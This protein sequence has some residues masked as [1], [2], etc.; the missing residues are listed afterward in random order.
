M[1]NPRASR[2]GFIKG[3]AA[4]LAGAFLALRGAEPATAT[5]PQSARRI[6][7]PFRIEYFDRRV[8]ELDE[9]LTQ[10]FNA[11]DEHADDGGPPLKETAARAEWIALGKESAQLQAR[12][13]IASP[14]LIVELLTSLRLRKGEYESIILTIEETRD[15]ISSGPNERFISVWRGFDGDLHILEWGSLRESVAAIQYWSAEILNPTFPTLK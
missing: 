13:N 7:T 10:L 14:K 1:T 11:Y 12:N 9:L 8:S 5:S 2:R 6:R 3:A 4:G 15:G